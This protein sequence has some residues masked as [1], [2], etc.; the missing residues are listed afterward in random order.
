MEALNKIRVLARIYM[1]FQ[2]MTF[3]WAVI[4]DGQVQNNLHVI[5]LESADVQHLMQFHD[6]FY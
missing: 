3:T 4:Q 1:L 2:F 6:T 5:L